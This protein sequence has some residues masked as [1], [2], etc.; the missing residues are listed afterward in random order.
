MKLPDNGKII[1]LST[2]S[3]KDF[4]VYHLTLAL[5]YWWFSVF[6]IWIN[7]LFLCLRKPI[8]PVWSFVATAIEKE[9][10]FLT[11]FTGVDSKEENTIVTFSINIDLQHKN[12]LL[13]LRRKHQNVFFPK[14]SNAQRKKCCP[15][16]SVT[17]RTPIIIF[18]SFSK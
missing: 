11:H 6:F 15:K 12:Y 7:H 10:Q 16:K 8:K 4:L 3:P 2:I 18:L 13:S 17:D 9:I 1:L 5:R 14:H